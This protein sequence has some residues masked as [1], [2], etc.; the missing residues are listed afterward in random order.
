MLQ[1]G[2]TS[3]AIVW[4]IVG[5][6]RQS[7]LGD[8]VRPKLQRAAIGLSPVIHNMAQIIGPLIGGIVLD[9]SGA[10]AAAALSAILVLPA[11]PL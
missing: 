1:L 5:P 11:I 4:A 10:G 8:L 2:A 3:L 9:V 6:A 7:I